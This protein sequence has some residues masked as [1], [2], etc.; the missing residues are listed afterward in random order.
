[1]RA[2]EAQ[3][4]SPL[5]SLYWYASLIIKAREVGGLIKGQGS[6]R[7]ANE[8]PPWQMQQL[9]TEL[10]LNNAT[11]EQVKQQQKYTK[12]TVDSQ[13]IPKDVHQNVVR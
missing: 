11:W 2:P 6:A 5:L 4:V 12:Q 7:T 9:H 3:S 13:L 1:M 8:F 10:T